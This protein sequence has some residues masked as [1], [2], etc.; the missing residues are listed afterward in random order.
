MSNE[1]ANKIL[2]SKRIFDLAVKKYKPSVVIALVS[3]GDDSMAMYAVAEKIGYIDHVVHVDTTTGIVAATNFVKDEVRHDLIIARTPE[4]NYEEIVLEHG[5]PG[6][7]QHQTMYNLLKERA[8]RVVQRRFQY[9]NSFCRIDGSTAHKKNTT[10]IYSPGFLGKEALVIKKPPRTIMYLSGGRKDESIRRMGTVKE[11]HKAG[12][13]IW[14]S[15]IANWT[16]TDIYNFRKSEKL[17]RSPTSILLDR[18]GEC[19]C[20]A[21]GFP[22]ELLEMKYHFPND[23]N[24]KMLFRVQE[25]LKSKNHKYSCYGHAAENRKLKSDKNIEAP[26][27]STC[28]NNH[29]SKP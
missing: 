9:D 13:Q 21:Y 7:G 15:L 20:G 27:C 1:L 14:V 29:L 28:I 5:F 17:K 18:S 8:L 11:I 12:N 22:Q 23:P 25:E 4:K 26:M 10:L 19:N 16:K 3:G 6:P 24:V 2:D